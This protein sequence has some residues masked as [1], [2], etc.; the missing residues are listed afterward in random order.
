MERERPMPRTLLAVVGIA[1]TGKTTTIKIVY[2]SI[3]TKYRN[4]EEAR[5]VPPSRGKEIRIILTIGKIKIGILSIGDS[6]SELKERLKYFEQK[7]C[8]II[9]C[10]CRTKGSTFKAAYGMEPKYRVKPFP[11]TKMES[12]RGQ[13]AD[14]REVA[15]RIFSEVK[16]AM[17]R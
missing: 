15:Q 5:I 14:N 2:E 6:R 17:A 10:A 16:R 12:A 9:V 7:E 8:K 3:K 4:F 11:K 1:N 13:D